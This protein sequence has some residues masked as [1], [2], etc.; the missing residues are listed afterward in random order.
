MSATNLGGA[1]VEGDYYPTP[2]WCVKAIASKISWCEIYTVGEPC[3]GDGAIL[4]AIPKKQFFTTEISEGKDYFKYPLPK[5]DL[6]I[7]NPPYNLAELF[8]RQSL[9]EARC[10]VYLLR[11]NFLGSAKRKVFFDKYRPTHLYVLSERPSFVDVCAGFE[12]P[13]KKK[14]CG[15]AYQKSAAVKVC[16]DCGGRVK[17]GTDATEYAWFAWDSDGIMEEDPGIY[18]L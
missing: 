17:A 1:R 7:T 11:I 3:S 9:K 10:V 15:A 6:I 16:H 18:V 13:V 4:R 14:G 5:V 2:E 12:R 8:L